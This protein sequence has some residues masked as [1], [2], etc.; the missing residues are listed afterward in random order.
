M[1]LLE[2][3]RN[4]EP[5]VT[6]AAFGPSLRAL[7]FDPPGIERE[8]LNIQKPD[9]I[10]AVHRSHIDAGADVILTNTFCANAYQFGLAGRADELDSVNAAAAAAARAAADDALKD[11]KIVYAIGRIGPQIGRAHV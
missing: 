8:R 5:L 11:G 3:I 9:L 1:G 2:R 10:R 7:G 4:A 6:D